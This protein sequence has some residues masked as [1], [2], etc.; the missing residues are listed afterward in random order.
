MNSI[1][2]SLLFAAAL[3]TAV[4]ACQKP[5]EQRPEKPEVDQ[6]TIVFQV[7]AG[8]LTTEGATLTV[9]HNG[10][11][12]ETYYCF[13]YTD[14][15]TSVTNAINREVA[16]LTEAG[17]DASSV[18]TTGTTHISV[19]KG[20]EPLTTYRYVVFG[21]NDDRSI[22][23]T[24]ASVDF[25]T[26]K[27]DVEFTVSVSGITE[28][29]ATASVT[30]TGDDT[31]TWY[32]FT[33]SDLTS[34]LDELVSAE[35]ERLG[36][37]LSSVLRSGNDEVQFSGLS[38]GTSYRAIVTGLKSDGTTYGTPV[39]ASFRTSF[40]TGDYVEN[41][42]WT[43]TYAGKGTYE[44][45][46]ADLL[47]VTVSAGSDPYTVGIIP[48]ADL[49][50]IGIAA[51]VEQMIL[52]YLDQIDMLNAMGI[53]VSWE[54]M[55]STG[56]EADMPFDVLDSSV[57]Y[58]GIAFGVDFSGKP[59]GLYALSEPF[60]PEELEA[61]DAYNSWLG[62]WTVTGANGV[63]NVL[64]ISAKSADVSYTVKGWQLGDYS[65]NWPGITAEFNADGS[66]SFI[67][68]EYG[69]IDT[70]NYGVGTLGCFGVIEIGN[71]TSIV[72]GT[73][74]MCTAT[75]DGTSSAEAVGESVTLTNNSTYEIISMEYSVILTGAYEGSVL[76]YTAEAPTF[77]LTMTK[78]A[79]SGQAKA[80]R[81]DI[82]KPAFHA[83]SPAQMNSEVS[84]VKMAE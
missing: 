73:Y 59:T 24:P 50:E 37:N 8:A 6:S 48:V 41:P 72:T 65:D 70:G 44:D 27:G 81:L 49:E 62:T 12:N 67:S 69:N 84:L 58:Y 40:A 61:S 20:L 56:T 57:E 64:E 79:A 9:T 83:L 63:E 54:D 46:P 32:C 34:S 16:G 78:E 14:L 82:A 74:P 39:A 43:V 38:D 68:E 22:Y 11:D 36:G 15:E 18:V 45:A 23:G 77:P 26:L 80:V 52:S 53:P 29:S 5:E 4:S 55:L 3:L 33:S 28:S 17:I 7:K 35:V 19:L 2:K 71:E 30:S 13:Y 51:F 47:T 75:L 1:N 25:T 21:L 31:D 60:Y 42:N 66:I 76:G 10:T